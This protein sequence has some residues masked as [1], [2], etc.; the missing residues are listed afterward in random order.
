MHTDKDISTL[1][2]WSQD[3]AKLNSTISRAARRSLPVAP[4]SMTFSQEMLRPWERASCE[5]TIMCNQA[6]GLSRL[7]K[8][9]DAISSQFKTLHSDKSKD[10]SSE[11]MQQAVDSCEYLVTFNQ[12][13]SQAMAR[14]M[15]DLSEGVFISMANFTLADRRDSYLEYL[16]AGVKQDSQHY[17]LLSFTCIHFSRTIYSSKLKRKYPE[18][19]RGILLASHTGNP[20]ISIHTLPM[21]DLLNQTRNLLSQLGNKSEN[22]KRERKV[23]ASPPLSHRNRPRVLNC[24]NDN[25]CVQCVTRL[26]DSVCVPGQLGLNPLPMVDKDKKLTSKSEI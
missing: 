18:A 24:V 12:S 9:Q 7:T 1:C 13:I 4:P 10:K 5:Q 6:A 11:R 15:Q 16:H 19:R 3:P 22:A 26:K 25:Y 21:T 8:V 14:T 17:V 20:V 2:A 23:V